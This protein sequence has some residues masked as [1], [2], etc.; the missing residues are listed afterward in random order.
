VLGGPA[1]TI[2]GYLGSEE[3]KG[4]EEGAGFA[5]LGGCSSDAGEKEYVEIWRL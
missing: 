4:S 1:A 5:H 2:E 3:G